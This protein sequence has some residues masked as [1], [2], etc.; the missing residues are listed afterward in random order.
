MGFL[1]SYKKKLRRFVDQLDLA[2]G[3]YDGR[4][5]RLAALAAFPAQ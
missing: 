1:S 3:T 4:P 2:D 5:A